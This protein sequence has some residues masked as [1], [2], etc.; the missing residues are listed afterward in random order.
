MENFNDFSKRESDNPT[1]AN[2]QNLIGLIN[3][4]ATKYDGKSEN[5]LLLAIINEAERSRNAGTLT[6]SDIDNFCAFLAPMLDGF[7]RKKLYEI[8]NKLKS[9]K[10]Q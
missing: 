1:N 3:M 5:E 8:C 6:D 10:L 4:L 7:K 2:N 9:K